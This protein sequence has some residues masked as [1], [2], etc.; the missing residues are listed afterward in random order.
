MNGYIDFNSEILANPEN[1][2][3]FIQKAEEILTILQAAKIKTVVSTTK[4]EASD[5]ID[6]YLSNRQ[7]AYD[8]LQKNLGDKGYPKI[9]LG[10][11]VVFSKGVIDIEEINHLC[12]ADTRYIMMSLPEEYSDELFTDIQKLI[13]SR[14]IYPVV[15][16]IE[17][18]VDK[19]SIEQIKKLASLG[20]LMQVSCQSI[21][22][23]T[24][25]RL[26]L[27]LL[28]KGIAQIIGSDDNLI[29]KSDERTAAEVVMDV[30]NKDITTNIM[31]V[32]KPSPQYADAVRIMRYNLPIGKYKQI[33]NNAGM[34]ISNA[35][36]KDILISDT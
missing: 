36:L 1:E 2:E 30:L 26:A 14:N 31:D 27:D 19:Y 15:A 32:A 24:T 23:R 34:V 6:N 28:N 10:S 18:Y 16:C 13:I 8:I 12:I 29:K 3:K 5:D 25:R 4:F 35:T 17:K 33:K 21:V 9:L 11:E 20:M 22:N 7:L